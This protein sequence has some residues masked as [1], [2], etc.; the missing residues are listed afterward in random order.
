M[1]GVTLK[2][3]GRKRKYDSTIP[4]HIDQTKIPDSIY[5][6]NTS[7]IWRLK[8]TKENGKIQLRRVAGQDATNADLLRIAADAMKVTPKDFD[9]L[10]LQFK[11]SPEYIRLKPRSKSQFDGA[12]SALANTLAV[13]G[14][15]VGNRP[16][17]WWTAGKAQAHIDE[18][19]KTRGPSAS[20][21]TLS[22]LK[23]CWNWGASL[24]YCTSDVVAVL[25]KPLE[26]AQELRKEGVSRSIDKNTHNHFLSFVWNAGQL[27]TRSQGSTP[28]YVWLA[29]EIAYLCK[30]RTIEVTF[31]DRGNDR[32]RYL[33]QARELEEGLRIVRAKGSRTN[34]VKWTPRLRQA[35]DIAKQ[36]RSERYK[37]LNI[38]TPI[39]P[40]DCPLIVNDSG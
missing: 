30:C 5:W 37:S 24:D 17:R 4:A 16:L 25:R 3:R 14:K 23:R 36:F 39:D 9:W 19:A 20:R 13:N 27:P 22:W 8:T 11:E 34:I 18:I 6:H 38:P 29:L 28:I 21:V 35:I 12:M 32:R 1:N 15:R 33:T 40:E 10:L 31:E 2:K 26:R 7:R